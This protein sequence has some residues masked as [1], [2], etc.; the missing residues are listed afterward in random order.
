MICLVDTVDIAS[1]SKASLG[2]VIDGF[3]NGRNHTT[4]TGSYSH[5]RMNINPDLEDKLADILSND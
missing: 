3:A 4:P 5:S 1:R 2:I